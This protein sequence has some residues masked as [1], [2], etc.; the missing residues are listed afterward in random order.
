[1]IDRLKNHQLYCDDLYWI[2]RKLFSEE[3][4]FYGTFVPLGAVVRVS[5]SL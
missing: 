1:M 3:S 5:L 4:H 2:R